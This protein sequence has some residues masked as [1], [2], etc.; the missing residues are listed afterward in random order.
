MGELSLRLLTD[1]KLKQFREFLFFTRSIALERKNFS[2][3][4]L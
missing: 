1:I 4:H 2:E 3:M